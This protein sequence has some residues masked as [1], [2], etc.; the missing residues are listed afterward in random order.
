[1]SGALIS[2]EA[3]APG[4]IDAVSDGL[5]RDITLFEQ[6]GCLSPHHVFIAS[7]TEGETRHFAGRIARSLDQLAQKLLPPRTIDVGAAA[8]IRSTREAARWRK[9]AGAAVDL[10]ESNEFSWSVI[11]DSTCA[12]RISPLYRTVFVA[13][14]LDFADFTA[15]LEPVSGHLEGFAIVDRA[16]RFEDERAWLRDAGVSYFAEPGMM[17]SPPLEWPHG[18]GAFLNRLVACG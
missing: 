11:Y 2:R 13:P 18:G 9:L 6:R 14:V 12:F 17:Q 5:A 1:V 4:A 16:G 3:L 10:W 8:A 15:R 7:A